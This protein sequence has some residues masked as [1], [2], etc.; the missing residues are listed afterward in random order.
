M[1]VCIFVVF[2]KMHLRGHG[3]LA[4]SFAKRCIVLFECHCEKRSC[5]YC[6]FFMIKMY[7]LGSVGWFRWMKYVSTYIY[8]GTWMIQCAYKLYL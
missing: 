3:R 5:C 4:L 2:L 6:K 1:Y 8:V 7:E